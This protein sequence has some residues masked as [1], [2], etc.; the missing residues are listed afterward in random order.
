[1][2]PL[3]RMRG[4]AWGQHSYLP[5]LGYWEAGK[6]GGHGGKGGCAARTMMNHKAGVGQMFR[7]AFDKLLQLGGELDFL[8]VSS[9]LNLKALGRVLIEWGM[10]APEAGKLK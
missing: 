5:V 6:L 9:P 8:K 7:E 1:M 10:P 2:T 3:G 4:E